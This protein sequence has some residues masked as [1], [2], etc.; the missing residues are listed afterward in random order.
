MS[1]FALIASCFAKF[2]SKFANIIVKVCEFLNEFVSSLQLTCTK[3]SSNHPFPSGITSH[4]SHFFLTNWGP[5]PLWHG[6]SFFSFI[7][8]SL[9][10]GQ[11]KKIFREIV[12][13]TKSIIFAPKP[14]K[15]THNTINTSNSPPH[16]P[17]QSIDSKKYCRFGEFFI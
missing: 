15:S 10:E 3:S 8:F 12:T 17:G 6:V 9:H 16:P 1:K 4:Y 2:S 13:Q 7:L 14:S 5:M 11:T